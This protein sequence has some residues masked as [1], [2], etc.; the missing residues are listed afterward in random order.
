VIL[1][2]QLDAALLYEIFLAAVLLLFWAAFFRA[3]V[4]KVV[5]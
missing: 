2:R 4:A 5:T 3:R 1:I